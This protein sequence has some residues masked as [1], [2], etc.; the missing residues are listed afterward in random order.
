MEG[1]RYRRRAGPPSAREPSGRGRGCRQS[2]TCRRRPC[3]TPPRS[4]APRP[5]CAGSWAALPSGGAQARPGL[6]LEAPEPAGRSAVRPRDLTAGRPCT[7]VTRSL[8][9]APCWLRRIDG[10]RE[11]DPARIVHNDIGRAPR[12][13]E[14]GSV[15]VDRYGRQ[16]CSTCSRVIATSSSPGPFTAGL[17][18][19]YSLPGGSLRHSR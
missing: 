9:H 16:S 12:C 18:D 8:A 5:G 13:H 2:W 7:A 10:D 11:H 17:R 4:C 3:P 6:M 1:R 14:V 15:R 19:I